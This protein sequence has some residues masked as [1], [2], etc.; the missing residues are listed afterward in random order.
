MLYQKRE[1]TDI[2]EQIFIWHLIL[3]FA[4]MKNAQLNS[5]ITS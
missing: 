4:N 2:K 5:V 3:W 1:V